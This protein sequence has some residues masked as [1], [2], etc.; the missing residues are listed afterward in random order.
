MFPGTVYI[1]ITSACLLFFSRRFFSPR[2]VIMQS[3]E[4]R[5]YQPWGLAGC[6][7]LNLLARTRRFDILHQTARQEALC[8]RVPSSE[9]V[10]SA[11]GKSP[12]ESRQ[13]LVLPPSPHPGPKC[14]S[15]E[16]GNNAAVMGSRSL[17]EFRAFCCPRP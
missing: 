1:S 12:T 2:H 9:R 15:S 13:L 17:V 16:Y 3:A 10:I 5:Y 6:L 7:W 11:T 14:P 4:G 8:R